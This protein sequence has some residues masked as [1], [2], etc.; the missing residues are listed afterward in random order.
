MIIFR[1]LKEALE[2]YPDAVVA[3]ARMGNC[4]I[5]EKYRD[6]RCGVCFNCSP[7]VDGEPVSKGHRLWERTNPQNTWYVGA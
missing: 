5:C 3:S 7:K 1:S 4:R 2:K 6:L